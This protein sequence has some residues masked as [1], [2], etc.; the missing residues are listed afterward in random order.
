ML[1]IEPRIMVRTFRGV[2]ASCLLF[3]HPDIILAI[4]I[5]AII[6]LAIIILA[7]IILAIIISAIIISAI[8]IS[9]I[10]ISAI[11]ISAIIISA[12]EQDAHIPIILFDF[13]AVAPELRCGTSDF[14]KG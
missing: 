7:I 14:I 4:I 6:I 12:S 10:I 3:S 11:I 13:C 5:L 1:A 2:Q 8:I 9:A